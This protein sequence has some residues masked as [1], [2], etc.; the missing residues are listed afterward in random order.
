MAKIELDNIKMWES[1]LNNSHHLEGIRKEHIVNALAD[2]G[3]RFNPDTNKI[4]SIEPESFKLEEGKWY[5]CME[6]IYDHVT[7]DVIFKEGELFNVFAITPRER[8]INDHFKC[9]DKLFR[10]AT[11]E[12]IPQEDYH[13]NGKI[14]KK[15]ATGV[16]K[17]MLDNI[18]E[19]E[20]AKTREEM[21]KESSDGE[22]TEFEDRLG[23]I[24]IPTWDITKECEVC[25]GT[26]SDIKKFAKELMDLA[27]KQI[28]E[29]ACKWLNQWDKY[30]VCLEGRKDW[31]IE[32]FRKSLE[33]GE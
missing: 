23:E 15:E 17:E 29:D 4:E 6:D 2:Q 13:W 18:D 20:L 3:L 1:I 5:V 32:Q 14:D 24:M 10:P 27:R 28:V 22:L 8:T 9:I 26:V 7:D 19:E 31:F 12:E 33:K 11:P 25:K 16:L 30:R 21:L